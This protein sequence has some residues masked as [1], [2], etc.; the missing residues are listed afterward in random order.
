MDHR[1]ATGV[2]L[3]FMGKVI[4]LCYHLSINIEE[5]KYTFPELSSAP[6][7]LYILVLT[8]TCYK[9]VDSIEK[10]SNG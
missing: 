6:A 8:Q 7:C 3:F 10:I 2:L 1:V 9:I 5:I 4:S